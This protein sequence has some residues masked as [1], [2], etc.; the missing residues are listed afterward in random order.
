MK[1]ALFL[2]ALIVG[3]VTAGFDTLEVYVT[4]S[5]EKDASGNTTVGHAGNTPTCSEC[6]LD[7]LYERCVEDK[8]VARGAVLE[9]QRRE[10]RGSRDLFTCSVCNGRGGVRGSWC[11]VICGVRRRL[12]LADEHSERSLVV[13][14]REL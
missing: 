13:V 11:W 5:F 8:A 1:Y 14:L 4:G 2:L 12:T 7:K 9:K 3:S 6:L 10:L